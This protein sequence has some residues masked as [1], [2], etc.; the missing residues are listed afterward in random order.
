[1]SAE[2][3]RFGD[4]EV[5]QEI[6]LVDLFGTPVT[7]PLTQQQIGQ[8]AIDIIL[9][10]TS[11]GVGLYGNKLKGYSQD[12]KDSET[13]ALYGKS[14][15]VNMELTGDMLA[16]LDIMEADSTKIVLGFNNPTDAAKAT[17]HQYGISKGMPERPFFGV[18]LKELDSIRAQFEDDIEKPLTVGDLEEGLL[19]DQAQ[20]SGAATRT[21]G[22]I[23]EDDE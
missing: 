5:I 19:I 22:N 7:N 10:R 21:I 18:N 12:Y 6:D 17:N 14:S 8:A 2:I 16:A 11:K 9:K 3:K 20:R 4:Y 1:M 15:T 23:F 13:F